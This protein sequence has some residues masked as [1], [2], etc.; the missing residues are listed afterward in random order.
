MLKSVEI[1]NFRSGT[2]YDQLGRLTSVDDLEDGGRWRWSYDHMDN[3][4]QVEDNRG[5]C[6]FLYDV[7]NRLVQLVYPDGRD[8]RIAYDQCGRPIRQTDHTG[9]WT[10]RYNDA[11]ELIQ[12]RY[13]GDTVARFTYDHKS[14]LVL[15]TVADR[16][17][18]YLYGPADELLAITDEQ[19]TPIRLFVHTPLGALAEI[20]GPVDCGAVYFRHY[21]DR[22]TCHLVTDQHGDMVATF[23]YCPFGTPT[24][25]GEFLPVFSGRIWYPE[26]GMYHFGAR[27]Y[28]PSWG[29]FLTPDTYTGGPDDARLVHPFNAASTQVQGRSQILSDW[30]HQPRL[31][32][33]YAFCVND[34]INRID[35]NGHWSILGALLSI[36]GAIWTL[37]NTLIGLVLEITCIVGEVIRWLVWLLSFGNWNWEPIGFDAAASGRLNAFALV[38]EGGWLGSFSSLLGITFGNVFFVYNDWRQHPAILQLPATVSP[39]AY[40]GRVSFPREQALYEHELRHT[41][42]YGWFGPFFLFGPPFGITGLYLWDWAL[43][44]FNYSNMWVERDASNYGGF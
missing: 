9:Q 27:W 44:G 11:G 18:R 14:R 3:R 23:R 19:G 5:G 40:E 16:T 8:I 12:V 33:R 32:N 22:G 1:V 34:P 39:S 43:S 4:R 13:R 37:P 35:P 6:R 28:D 42:Q 41:N 17:E 25:T 2:T 24:Y 21:D 7:D 29:R 31:R 26:L 38:F 20:R 36:L 10:Y 15:S 30:L